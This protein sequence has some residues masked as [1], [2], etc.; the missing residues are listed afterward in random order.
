MHVWLRHL[1]A[2]F[3]ISIVVGKM[4]LQLVAPLL[5]V[6]VVVGSP[7]C[8]RSITY[9]ELWQLLENS[10]CAG[11][12][13]ERLKRSD[14]SDT[15]STNHIYALQS[16]INDHRTMIDDHRRM[17]HYI[18]NTTVNI[19]QFNEFFKEHLTQTRPIW[20]SWRDLSIMLLV[21]L[22]IGLILYLAIV[23]LHPLDL[24]TQ[25][26]LQR[27]EKK[28]RGRPSSDDSVVYNIEQ[29]AVH[30]KI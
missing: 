3:Q 20:K 13:H 9:D 15:A 17:I 5:L 1:L 12:N 7:T 4:A 22:A 2:S 18:M 24:L 19:T 16:T 30:H 6:L 27:H 10:P 26:L 28:R 29:H 14:G 21:A 23:Y 11:P 8:H 25:M